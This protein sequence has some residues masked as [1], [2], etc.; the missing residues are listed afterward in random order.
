M[1]ISFARLVAYIFSSGKLQPFRSPSDTFTE[2]YTTTA[3]QAVIFLVLIGLLS[4][5]SS[6]YSKARMPTQTFVLWTVLVLWELGLLA[7]ALSQYVTTPYFYDLKVPLFQQ[8]ETSNVILALFMDKQPG[9]LIRFVESLRAVDC[10]ASIFIFCHH[11]FNCEQYRMAGLQFD[12]HVVGYRTGW[13]G[14]IGMYAYDSVR[15]ELFRKFLEEYSNGVFRRIMIAEIEGARFQVDP[16]TLLD[17]GK[18]AQAEKMALAHSG[19]RSHFHNRV[20]GISQG[21]K[22][23][24]DIGLKR[25]DIFD[26]QTMVDKAGEAYAK[27]ENEAGFGLGEM[28]VAAQGGIFEEGGVM[29]QKIKQCFGSGVL[30]TLL[31]EHRPKIS[32]GFVIGTLYE[33]NRY[34]RT[35]E[36]EAGSKLWCNSEGMH[37]AL[38]NV[39]VHTNAATLRV[40]SMVVEDVY[41]GRIATFGPSKR[42]NCFS[43]HG[44]LLNDEGHP[45]VVLMRT[46]ECLVPAS[47]WNH[48][49][50]DGTNIG[51]TDLEDLPPPKYNLGHRDQRADDDG[52]S[53]SWFGFGSLKKKPLPLP[54]NFIKSRSIAKALVAAQWAGTRRFEHTGGAQQCANASQINPFSCYAL[55]TN[56]E[57]V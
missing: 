36:E 54:A 18:L 9:P 5:W 34:F 16:F 45:Y 26:D 2:T 29:E 55:G 15:Y 6:G 13:G 17:A 47:L 40:P 30:Q 49:S 32:A 22:D 20:R 46:D 35:M 12:F 31:D 53:H 44:Q 10:K 41:A 11:H 48:S 38:H 1:V 51:E 42:F 8:A 33:M 3:F 4:S 52:N 24:A 27:G 56:A 37:E 19:E 39:L 23:K 7:Y 21:V 57:F 28:I 43:P 25:L 14:D 50:T